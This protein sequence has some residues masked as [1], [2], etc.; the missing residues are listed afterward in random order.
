MAVLDADFGTHLT[1]SE[2]GDTPWS[3]PM[4]APACEPLDWPSLLEE[5]EA[6]VKEE[7]IRADVADL[8][9]EELRRSERDSRKLAT[10]L[11]RQLGTCRTSSRWPLPS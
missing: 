6:R 10:S 3:L 2:G 11:R 9:C 8:R 7:R 5:A 4:V 1:P